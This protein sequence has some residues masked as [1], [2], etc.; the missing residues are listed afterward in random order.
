MLKKSC[1]GFVLICLLAGVMPVYSS[2]ERSEKTDVI[3]QVDSLNKLAEKLSFDNIILA[4]S[5]AFKAA[6][7]AQN[8]N[9]RLGEATAYRILAGI[10]NNQEEYA[11]GLEYFYKSAQ[12]YREMNEPDKEILILR[13]I[14]ELF[15]KLKDPER[16]VPYLEQAEDLLPRSRDPLS[17]LMM[18]YSW[19]LLAM[20]K[21]NYPKAIDYFYHS[22]G[23]S[24]KTGYTPGLAR[25]YRVIGD[26]FVQMK[27]LWK[28]IFM[29]QKAIAVHR[30]L[31]ELG[32]ISVI[33]TRIAHAYS[34][35]GLKDMAL[36]YNLMAYRERIVAGSKT[37]L[38]SSLINIGGSYM[39]SGNLD[40]A[41]A[42]LNSGLKKSK[43]E[44]RTFL[45]EEAE[46]LLSQSYQ[47]N[48]Q[49]KQ[50]IEHY[51]EYVRLHEA[52]MNERNKSAI[53]TLETE[54]LVTEVDNKH[55]LLIKQVEAQQLDLR[56]H[57][58]QLAF[59]TLIAILIIGVGLIVYILTKRIKRSEQELQVLNTKL[60]N[61]IN[62]HR[63]AEKRLL[64]SEN[65][66]RFIAEH[67]PDVISRFGSDLRRKFVSP[68]CFAMYGY[69]EEELLTRPD[70]LEIVDL[71]YRKQ[72]RSSLISIMQKNTP[73]TIVYKARRKDGTSFWVE[74]HV[75]PMPDPVTGK[76]FETITVVR[77]I[78]DRLNYEEQLAENERQKEVL[79][80]EIH[81]RVKNNFAILISLMDLQKQFAKT[82]T[83]D[84]QLIDLQLRVRT[85]S[86]V[87]E[88]L[89]H[90]HSIDAIPLGSYL[91]RLAAVIS[92]A[93]SKPNI[94]VHTKVQEC[95]TRI[96]IALPLGLI[97][98][99]LLT[100]SFK[101]AFPD[102]E[103]G[104][105]WISL[106]LDKENGEQ[107]DGL[108]SLFYILS[109]KDNGVGLPETFSFEENTSTG[110]R[111]IKILVEQLEAVY[112]ISRKP[113]ACFTIRFAAFPKDFN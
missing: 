82:D 4:R 58:L 16:A 6:S 67:L 35:L 60:G 113:G 61:E 24:I 45:T 22:A 15:F 71:N 76:P 72:V 33:N 106:H 107:A 63:I 29:Y 110:S 38:T 64:E 74:N 34:V 25:N 21:K 10:S 8:C 104:D 78:S 87:H 80:Y 103:K 66:Y 18:D 98:N 36:K 11:Q 23:L 2:E 9:Y 88:Q 77:D 54:H 92:S 65:L 89:Y 111:I 48:K 56:N 52:L 57:R 20:E 68:S 55:N 84:M 50:S 1:I 100:N 85:M 101:Y 31:D 97:V 17:N 44:G 37:L 7:Q 99:E 109:V 96:E 41:F 51:L 95:A 40:S 32:E 108:Q 13:I 19:G 28:A 62:E 42:Y 69:T 70:S 12:I 3:K 49:Y 53:R 39:E 59:M 86:L 26:A 47:Q 112:E 93:F 5:A 27:Q 94:T 30:Q 90:N 14:A 83:L 91:E 102:N 105:V 81:H 73:Q 46:L 79:L 75:N 43:A